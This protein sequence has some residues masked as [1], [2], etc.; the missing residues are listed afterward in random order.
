[1]RNHWDLI[2]TAVKTWFRS[3][4]FIWSELV[5]WLLLCYCYPSEYVWLNWRYQVIGSQWN[6]IDVSQTKR[7]FVESGW[8]LEPLLP[9]TF[10]LPWL[11]LDN[12]TKLDTFERQ[13]GVIGGAS[14]SHNHN[15]A[16]TRVIE[17]CD[18]ALYRALASVIRI[19]F[20]KLSLQIFSLWLWVFCDHRCN[21]GSRVPFDVDSA[22]PL[23]FQL[24][25]LLCLSL[26]LSLAS[27]QALQQLWSFSLLIDVIVTA[28][29]VFSRVYGYQI[30]DGRSYWDFYSSCTRFQRWIRSTITPIQAVWLDCPACESSAESQETAIMSMIR[31]GRLSISHHVNQQSRHDGLTGKVTSKLPWCY[32]Y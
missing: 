31:T 26:A 30:F 10:S 17:L 14:A 24:W 21:A 23:S 15:H 25:A 9:K 22:W 12:L 1:M 32:D 16:N 6:R 2:S 29:S 7:P 20:W 4:C 27:P 13:F 8:G 3:L 18:D 5:L 28:F 11:W 19:Q